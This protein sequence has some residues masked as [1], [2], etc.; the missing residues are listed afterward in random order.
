[1]ETYSATTRTGALGKDYP[2]TKV[3]LSK[4]K[5]SQVLNRRTNNNHKFVGCFLRGHGTSN[6]IKVSRVA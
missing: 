6:S 5:D 1:M 2:I 4:T 3:F